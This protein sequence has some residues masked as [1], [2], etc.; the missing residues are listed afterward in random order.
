VKGC[1]FY[2]A[3]GNKDFHVPKQVC[4]DSLSMD[5]SSVT[6][7]PNVIFLSDA[8]HRHQRRF[9]LEQQSIKLMT[10]KGSLVGL[11][12]PCTWISKVLC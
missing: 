2:M 10:K 12:I 6:S 5:E 9:H 3:S 8:E 7:I 11:P 1:A 4:A